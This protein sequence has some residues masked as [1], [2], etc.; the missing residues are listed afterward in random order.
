MLGK[1]SKRKKKNNDK[2]K[3]KKL[4]KNRL[5]IIRLSVNVDDLDGMPLQNLKIR[6]EL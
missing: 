5:H 3:Q 6:I 1:K 4:K 2:A